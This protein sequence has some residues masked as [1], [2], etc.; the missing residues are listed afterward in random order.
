M[1]Y[2]EIAARAAQRA[3]EHAHDPESHLQVEFAGKA[4]EATKTIC[5]A[6]AFIQDAIGQLAARGASAIDDVLDL[7]HE[8]GKRSS[9][10]RYQACKATEIAASPTD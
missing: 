8:A 9:L 1:T 2:E 6:D 5:E 10:A 3:K 4:A 7:L